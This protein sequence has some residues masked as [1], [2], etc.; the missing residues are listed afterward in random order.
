MFREERMKLLL[1]QLEQEGQLRVG[2]AA[3]L[4]GVSESTI[5]LDLQELEGRG[6]VQRTHGGA[7]LT[8]AARSGVL[9]YV[10][11]GL[12]ERLIENREAKMAIGQRTADLIEDG[13]TI[14]I[15]GGSTARYVAFYLRHKKRLTLVTHMVD[16]YPDLIGMDGDFR[17]V[18]TGGE[19]DPVNMILV[20]EEAPLIVSHFRA[21]TAVLGMDG[22]SLSL[23]VTS[24]DVHAPLK[25]A[26]MTYSSR[27]I[28]VADSTKLGRVSLVP[29]A[30]L[31]DIDVLVTDEGADPHMVQEIE[32]LGVQ[33]EIA[34]SEKVSVQ[35]FH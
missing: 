25:R 23:G 16:I 20:G 10:S 19:L 11:L 27:V 35:R 24:Q 9:K 13:E 14:M 28:I 6:L 34:T 1:S 7:I 18:M 22:N 2:E 31:A 26:M 30:A 33:V 32:A 12:E 5:R 29:V 3:S 17:V 4:F 15:D 8:S 21:S